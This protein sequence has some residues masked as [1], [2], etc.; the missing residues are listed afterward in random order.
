MLFANRTIRWWKVAEQAAAKAAGSD[1]D[2]V[3]RCRE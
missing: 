3:A 2:T 1:V